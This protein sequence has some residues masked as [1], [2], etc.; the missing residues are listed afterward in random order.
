M[1]LKPAQ[2]LGDESVGTKIAGI[3]GAILFITSPVWGKILTA[4][5]L[6]FPVSNIVW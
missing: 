5:Y 1:K 3:I 4:L 6:G 2:I